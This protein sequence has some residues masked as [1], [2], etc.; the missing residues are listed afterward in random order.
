MFDKI[1]MFLFLFPMFLLVN[2]FFSGFRVQ[3]LFTFLGW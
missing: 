3:T 2:G 1:L